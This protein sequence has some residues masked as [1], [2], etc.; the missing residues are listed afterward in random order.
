[1]SGIEYPFFAF[2]GFAVCVAAIV[3]AISAI[4]RR[5]EQGDDGPY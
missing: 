2:V 3:C 5:K 4:E 1:M